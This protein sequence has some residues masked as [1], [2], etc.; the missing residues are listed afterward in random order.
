MSISSIFLF[1]SSILFQNNITTMWIIFLTAIV[2]I[3][4]TLKNEQYKNSLIFALV[5]GSSIYLITS[6]L[7]ETIIHGNTLLILIMSIYSVAL[8]TLGKIAF[9]DLEGVKNEKN[10]DSLTLAGILILSAISLGF[11]NNYTDVFITTAGSLLLVILN[12]RKLDKSITLKTFLV[13]RLILTYIQ[14]CLLLHL[15]ISGEFAIIPLLA[16]AITSRY[17][18]F[19]DNKL[20]ETSEIITLILL[21]IEILSIAFNLNLAKSIAVITIGVIMLV[22]SYSKKIKAYFI[23]SLV[24]IIPLFINSTLSFWIMI[25]WW[26]YLLVFGAILIILGSLS[27]RK[28]AKIKDIKNELFKGWK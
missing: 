15:N 23:T 3:A 14:I 7:I 10:F 4:Y 25:P 5:T 26:V 16:W 6:I 13:L 9:K 28:D 22:I 19:K 24:M 11:S 17:W 18:I 12:F 20:G 27:E 21:N 2:M 8:S 1:A